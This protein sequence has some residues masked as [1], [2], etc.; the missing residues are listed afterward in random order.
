MYTFGWI[1]HNANFD[2]L[3]WLLSENEN[4]TEQNVYQKSEIYRKIMCTVKYM[5]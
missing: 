4:Y 3:I 5:F 1:L 2:M